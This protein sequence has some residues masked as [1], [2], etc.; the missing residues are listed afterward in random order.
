MVPAI[1]LGG[2]VGGGSEDCLG[3]SAA[4]LGRTVQSCFDLPEVQRLDGR[5]IAAAARGRL[6]PGI[7]PPPSPALRGEA[8]LFTPP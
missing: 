4:D 7:C 6:L 2:G 1:V 3:I 8:T 5:P